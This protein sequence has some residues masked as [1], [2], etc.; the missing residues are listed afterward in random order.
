[1]LE[2]VGDVDP[3][4]FIERYDKTVKA[5]D[6]AV[7]KLNIQRAINETLA[8]RNK[9]LESTLVSKTEALEA[10]KQRAA[11]YEKDAKEAERLNEDV[12]KLNKSLDRQKVQLDEL[13]ALA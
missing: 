8:S 4:E 7:Q 9:E 2:K 5:R 3:A 10:A 6:D 11:R 13:A 1:M 12:V